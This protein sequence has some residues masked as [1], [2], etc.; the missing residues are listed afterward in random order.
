MVEFRELTP[1]DIQVRTLQNPTRVVAFVDTGDALLLPIGPRYSNR[2]V[3]LVARAKIEAEHP[4]L[5]HALG[6]TPLG[7]RTS[8][9]RH[10]LRVSAFNKGTVSIWVGLD[11]NE[12]RS[13]LIERELR[14]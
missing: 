13:R 7:Y 8:R 4:N 2:E 10:P 14:R 12:A 3:A 1:D 6:P 11:N 5:V 9:L